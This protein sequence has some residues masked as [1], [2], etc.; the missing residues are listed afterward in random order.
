MKTDT[1]SREFFDRMYSE[2][3]DPWQFANSPYEL[4][5]YRAT[6]R[7]LSG[8]HYR[9]AF[10]PGCSIGVLTSSLAVICDK[11]EATDISSVA[12]DHARQRCTNL[13]NVSFSLG[14]LPEDIPEGSFDLIVFSEIGYYFQPFALRGVSQ[15]IVKRL[16]S[17]GV[18]LAVHWLGHSSDHI[19][20]GDQ[21]HEILNEASGLT[22][23]YSERKPG[24]RLDRWK[25]T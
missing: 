5:R 22:I 16:E 19:L 4:E 21:V 25:R 14:E 20:S 23:D 11:V 8:R 24:F 9:R 18:L 13:A 17:N 12:L 7:A 10:E 15:Q 1:T 2:N 6:L 3:A